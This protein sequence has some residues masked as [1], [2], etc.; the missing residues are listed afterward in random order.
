MNICPT[1]DT[2]FL[3]APGFHVDGQGP[4]YCGDGIAIEGVLA[5]Y[6]QVLAW[7]DVQRI[8]FERPRSAVVA[9]LGEAHQSLPVLVLA[10]D[11]DTHG[12]AFT[13]HGRLRFND[14]PD[15]IR[16]YLSARGGLPS[17]R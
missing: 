17:Q 2:L 1:R 8:A 9:L 14:Q 4:F 3:A 7:L 15:A 13:L 6:P 12:V 10:G 11:S 16:R 5:L